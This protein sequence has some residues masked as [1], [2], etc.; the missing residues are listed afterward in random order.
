MSEPTRKGLLLTG[1]FTGDDITRF[2]NLLRDVERE[3]PEEFF[4]LL[5]VDGEAEMSL[6]EAGQLVR[7][8]FPRREAPEEMH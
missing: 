6:E 2:A 3:R 1:P 7:K 8:I 5:V 4:T